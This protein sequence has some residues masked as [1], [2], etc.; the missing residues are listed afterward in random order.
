MTLDLPDLSSEV[1]ASISRGMNLTLQWFPEDVPLSV[2]AATLVG[3]A[4]TDGGTV[5]LGVSP[6]VGELVGVVYPQ[7]ALK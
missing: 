4:N 7:S 6:R 5:V 3:M 2:L 1:L